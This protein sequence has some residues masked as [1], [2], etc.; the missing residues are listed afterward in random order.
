[1]S[2][3]SD[4]LAGKYKTSA[5]A[6][7]ALRAAGGTGATAELFA[8]FVGYANACWSYA[9]QPGGQTAAALLAG[10][11][12]KTIACGT[13]REALKLM[14]REDLKLTDVANADI[15]EY[16]V[17]KPGL[18][19]FDP[20]VTGNVGNHGRGTF[21]AGCHFSTHYFLSTGGKFYDPCLMAV[22]SSLSGPIGERTRQIPNGQGLRKAGQG[23][24]LVIFHLL[25][26]RT[27]PG[28][29]SVWEI[30]KLEEC[31]AALT[32]AELQ[33][34]KNDPDVKAAKVL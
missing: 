11:G 27:V 21:N 14:L 20:K 33:T 4:I 9:A 26:G 15:N 30:L 22:Y 13:I 10:D 32:A 18:A 17:S 25:A 8:S 2:A 34:V 29:G 31:K 6:A 5:A 19:C 12:N 3:R 23:R 7:G 24:A 28:F 16:F 1:M